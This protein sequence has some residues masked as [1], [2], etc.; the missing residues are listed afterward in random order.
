[1]SKL[2]NV[3]WCVDFVDSRDKVQ[4]LVFSRWSQRQKWMQNT[5]FQLLKEWSKTEEA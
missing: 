5:G 4:T 1:M 2:C 3:K